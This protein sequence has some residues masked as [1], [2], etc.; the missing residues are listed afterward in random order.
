MQE[1]ALQHILQHPE[2]IVSEMEGYL[3]VSE[4]LRQEIR[5][6][7]SATNDPTLLLRHKTFLGVNLRVQPFKCVITNSFNVQAPPSTGCHGER[8]ASSSDSSESDEYTLH[9]NTVSF[10]A[11][12]EELRAVV[13]SGAPDELLKDFLLAADCDVNRALNFYFNTL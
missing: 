6:L 9:K 7:L 11:A 12:L 8:S 13:G 5:T 2:V 4:E 10:D 3:S 1:T